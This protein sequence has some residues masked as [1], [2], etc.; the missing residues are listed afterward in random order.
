MTFLLDQDTPD[1]LAFSLHALGHDAVFLRNVLPM[2]AE[3]EDVFNHAS[4]QGWIMITCNRDDF[5]ALAK[6]RPHAGLIILLRRKT[7]VAERAA[8]VRLLDNAGETGIRNN[9][10][11]A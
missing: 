6:S 9:I 7:R 10:N 2:D 8:L 3:D 5:L 4:K 1:D 11:F